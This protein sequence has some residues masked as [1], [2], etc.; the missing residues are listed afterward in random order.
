MTTAEIAEVVHGKPVGSGDTLVTGAAFVDSRIT[1]P[2]G[3]FVAVR[4]ERAD[5]HEFAAAAVRAGAAGVLSQ[6]ALGLPGVVVPDSVAALGALAG[7]VASRLTGARVVGITGSQGK[8]STKDLLAHLLETSGPTVAPVGS[9]N[10]EIG[11]PLTVLRADDTTRFLVV[12]MGARGLGHIRRLATMVRPH[13][14]VVLNVGVAHIGEFGSRQAIAKAK[15]ELVEALP[16]DGV[17]VLNAD[18]ELTAGMR[19][20]TSARTMLFGRS[21]AADVRIGDV[22]L[23][24]AGRVTLRLGY[25]GSEKVVALPLVGKHHAINAA[26]ATAA[27][28]ACGLAFDAICSA[29]SSASARSRW[30]METVTNADGVTVVNDAYNANP[31][32]MRSAL[33]TLAELGHRRG[34]GA[35]TFAVLGEMCELGETSLSEHESLGRLVA[36]LDISRLVAVGAAAGAIAEATSKEE[37]WQGESQRVPDAAAAREYLRAEVRPGDVVLVKASRAAG[38]ETVADV[39]LAQPTAAR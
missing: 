12:E 16:D 15:G 25:D 31:D 22:H 38:L 35:R 19:T 28:L 4:G 30:R 34:A 24:D 6:R 14:G 29:L 11:A 9:F 39:L 18:D 7:S 13:V 2:G 37:R 36:E 33:E 26:A 17:A 20:R 27:A 23:D 3:L 10:N 1:V 32:S 21:D 8:T 5:G